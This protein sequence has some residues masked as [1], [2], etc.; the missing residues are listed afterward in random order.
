MRLPE[1]VIRMNQ[2]R[3]RICKL[4]FNEDYELKHSFPVIPAALSL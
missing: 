1:S 2:S 4:K 3:Q